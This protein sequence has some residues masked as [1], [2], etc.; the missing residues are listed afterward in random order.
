V[1]EGQLTTLDSWIWPVALAPI[2]G[3]FLGVIV[4]RVETP[5]SIVFGRSCCPACGTRLGSADLV[6]LLSWVASRGRCRHCAKPIGAFYPLIELAAVGV[7]AWAALTVSGWLLWT[8]C[9]LGWTLL[10][11]AAIDFKYFLLPDFLTLPLIAAGLFVIWALDSPVLLPHAIGAVA[12]FAFVVA[13]RYLYW[14][15]RGREG[16]GLGDAKLLSASG[17][18]V[19]WESLTSV[20]L[21]AALS[22]LAFTLFSAARSGRI[23]L[24]DRVPFGAFLCFGTWIVWLYGPLIAD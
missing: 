11:L 17:A 20:V 9:L 3:S 22:A 21:I 13:I 15:L 23:S 10:A 4:T 14:K 2:A 19:S 8:S 12:G 7:A 1:L 6:P 24:A 16:M 5:A 18:W